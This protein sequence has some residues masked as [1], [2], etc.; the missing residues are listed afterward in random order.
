MQIQ[1]SSENLKEESTFGKFLRPLLTQDKTNTGKTQTPCHEWNSNQQIQCSTKRRFYVPLIARPLSSVGDII[2]NGNPLSPAYA[3]MAS[4]NTN[5]KRTPTVICRN[6]FKARR[7][8]AV[9]S[10]LPVSDF[11][12]TPYTMDRAVVTPRPTMN[13]RSIGT[14]YKFTPNGP[15]F[16]RK[17]TLYA[18]DRAATATVAGTVVLNEN[19][20]HAY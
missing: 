10:R 8:N 17:T 1:F 15:V 11:C 12:K 18:L 16:E 19:G 13:N 14:R 6:F 9:Q 3:F 7:T 4:L 20:K 2:T 5:L